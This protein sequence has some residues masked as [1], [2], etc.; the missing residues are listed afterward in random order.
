MTNFYIF[1]HSFIFF[2]LLILFSFGCGVKN[3]PI[4]PQNSALPS[5][6][7]EYNDTFD[8]KQDSELSKRK[9][10]SSN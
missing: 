5:F 7:K 1:K 4:P 6:V 10:T 8:S 2:Y 3:A 9:K